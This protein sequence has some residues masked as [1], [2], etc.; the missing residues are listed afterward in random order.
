M[1]CRFCER[2]D[3]G[4]FVIK[5]TD[6]VVVALANPRLVPGHL[7]I[8]PKEHVVRL[9]ELQWEPRSELLETV[10]EFQEKIMDRLSSGCD[11]RYGS[12]PTLPK[13]SKGDDHA[14][15]HLYP[16]EVNDEL[17]CR[18]QVYELALL[19]PPTIDEQVTIPRLLKDVK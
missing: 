14:H 16:R 6:R 9:G 5:D 19:S 7:V 12:L 1:A 2:G 11:I 15:I 18:S 17:F 10:V 13:Q 3:G 8:F 4:L